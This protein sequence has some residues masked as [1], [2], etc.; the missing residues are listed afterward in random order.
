MVNDPETIVVITDKAQARLREIAQTSAPSPQH[1]VRIGIVGG[2]CSGLSYHIDFDLS[3]DH[4]NIVDLQGA[5]ILVDPKSAIYLKDT[6]LDFQDGLGGKG[7]VFKNP[8]AT[9]TCGCGE[10]FS[11]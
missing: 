5:Q 10:S 1:G 3:Q 11:A 2:G 7:F 8:N 6:V 4:D 9:N